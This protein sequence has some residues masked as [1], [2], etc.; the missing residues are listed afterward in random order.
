MKS[1]VDKAISQVGVIHDAIE[2]SQSRWEGLSR[3]LIAYGG[4]RLILFVLLSCRASLFPTNFLCVIIETVVKGV[5]YVGLFVYYILLYRKEKG[6]SDKYYLGCLN[7]LGFIIFALPL[8]TFLLNLAF[9]VGQNAQVQSQR[10]ILMWDQ[11]QIANMLLFC[12]CA[13]ICGLIRER[14]GVTAGSVLIL[15]VYLLLSVPLR[16]ASFIIPLI[17]TK[18]GTPRFPYYGIYYNLVTSVGYIVI[19]VL[20]RRPGRRSNGDQ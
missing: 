15:I 5:L 13:V 16:D 12:L 6:A 11:E 2:R 14:R 10:M 18:L 4:V 9:N 1:D 19:G 3:M 7:L 20:L 17:V 8:S